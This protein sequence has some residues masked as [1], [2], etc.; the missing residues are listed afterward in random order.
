MAPRRFELQCPGFGNKGQRSC[1]FKILAKCGIMTTFLR[2]L[3]CQYPY[4]G[5]IPASVSFEY[6]PY[7]V[8]DPEINTVDSVDIICPEYQQ[9]GADARVESSQC[10]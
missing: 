7:Q 6:F 1:H 10:C 9:W 5:N 8:T 4:R 3:M 2:L